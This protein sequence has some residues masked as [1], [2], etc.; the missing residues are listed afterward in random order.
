MV[1]G[2]GLSGLGAA[3]RALENNFDVT[4]YER[5]DQIGGLWYYTDDPDH[6]CVYEGIIT[7]QPK[8]INQ[9]PDY[10]FGQKE[11]WYFS[12]KEVQEYFTAYAQKHNVDKVIKFNHEVVDISPANGSDTDKYWGVTVFDRLANEKE[13]KFFDF[14]AICSGHYKVPRIP[15]IKGMDL[16]KGQQMHSV[17][18][19]RAEPFR[20][21]G[22][23]P[24]NVFAD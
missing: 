21:E 15:Q 5:V 16:F 24:S 13:T 23:F 10:F 22:H 18:Y 7:N 20:G 4:V 9:L 6:T 2:A 19:R 17:K 3:R 12:A 1:I 14:V 11:Q 8:E